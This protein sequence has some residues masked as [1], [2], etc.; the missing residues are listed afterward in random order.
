MTSTTTRPGASS[1]FG[2]SVLNTVLSRIGTLG[3]GIVLARV[4]GPESF[5][6]FAVALVALMAVLSF[7]ELGVS[8]AIVRWPGDP[9]RIVPTVNTISVAG[10]ALFCTAAIFAAPV[11]TAAVGD[12]DA[13]GVIRVLILS[14]FINGIVASPAALLQRDFREKTRMG[15]DQANVWVGAVLSLALAVAGMGAMALAVGRVAGSLISAVMFLKASP[16]PYRFGLDRTLVGPLLR[17]GLPLAG[18]SIIFFAVGYSDQLTAGILLG[19]TGLG[20]YVL[21]FN[22]ASWP[23]SILAQPLRR[24]APAA[25]SSL[26][27]DPS[28][29]NDTLGAIF[30]VL[31]CVTLPPMVFLA[32]SSEPVVNLLYGMAWLP[33]AAVLSWLV[34]AAFAK[35]ICDL[36]YDFLVVLGRSGTVFMIQAVSL[37]VLIPALISGALLFGLA[38]LAAAQ[39]LVTGL[40]VLPCYLRQVRKAG[41]N[42]APM[43][44]SSCLPAS[45]GLA[46]G[47]FAWLMATVQPD[48]LPAVASSGLVAGALALGLLYLRR[49]SLGLLRTIGNASQTAGAV[50]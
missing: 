49:T 1:A 41:V 29:L 48:P 40:V 11:F 4:L 43:A 21:A 25:F 27:N 37:V 30:S 15:I 42:L 28:R 33:A 34:I 18:T 12:P 13:T 47:A 19:T 5:G 24:V 3:I 10:S 14:V 31:L 36:A 45:A 22:L 20:F 2:W 17:F 23:V 7:N 39:A 32:A 44:R 6:T 9:S 46:A 38:G 35:I 26:Q 50:A 16:L 8:L